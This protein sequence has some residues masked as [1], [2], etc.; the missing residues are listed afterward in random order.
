MSLANSL[1]GIVCQRLAQRATG[2]GRVAVVEVMVATERIKNFLV[3]PEELHQLEDAIAEGEFFGMQTFDQHLLKLYADGVVSLQDALSAATD[4][5]D[6]RVS[7]RA[8]GLA[9]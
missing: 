6:F 3:D 7:L 1:K 8:A 5:Q 9:K 4:Q 2:S